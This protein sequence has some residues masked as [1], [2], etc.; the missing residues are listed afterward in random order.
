MN[1][2]LFKLCENNLWVLRKIVLS[3]H[4]RVKNLLSKG[5]KWYISLKCELI[6]IFLLYWGFLQP[7]NR[8]VMVSGAKK[9]FLIH[10]PQDFLKKI[11]LKKQ[12]TPKFKGS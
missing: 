4:D 9:I 5:K 7:G 2:M 11:M 3:D 6:F 10:L 1:L 8:M 12:G